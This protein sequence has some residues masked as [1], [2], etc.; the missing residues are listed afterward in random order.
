M[1][2]LLAQARSISNS[3]NRCSMRCT[4]VLTRRDEHGLRVGQQLRV[5]Y[6][7]TIRDA[8]RHKELTERYPGWGTKE[9]DERVLGLDGR[10]LPR[11]R[12]R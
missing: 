7:R 2:N 5:E 8:K 6:N 11:R 1:R 9:V 10:P 3:G 12:D 4:G